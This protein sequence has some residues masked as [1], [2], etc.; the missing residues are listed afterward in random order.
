MKI[1][2]PE[3]DKSY[4]LEDDYELLIYGKCKTSHTKFFAELTWCKVVKANVWFELIKSVIKKDPVFDSFWSDTIGYDYDDPLFSAIEFIGFSNTCC[5]P[6]RI[7]AYYV[8]NV[9]H[10]NFDIMS[11]LQ[12]VLDYKSDDFDDVFDDGLDDEIDYEKECYGTI[13]YLYDKFTKS[14]YHFVSNKMMET[15]DDKKNENILLIHKI[16]KESIEVSQC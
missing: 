12:N 14:F 15:G 3:H 11:C 8:L 7:K 9:N 5:C 10:G 2:C 1:T 6:E 16:S 13:K 4:E